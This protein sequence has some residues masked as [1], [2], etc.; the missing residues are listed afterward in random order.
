MFCVSPGCPIVRD[1]AVVVHVASEEPG[2][3]V[4]NLT[5]K[6]EFNRTVVMVVYLVVG[7]LDVNLND[8]S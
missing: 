3:G 4:T 6:D 2:F 5:V 8:Y 7:D 1:D